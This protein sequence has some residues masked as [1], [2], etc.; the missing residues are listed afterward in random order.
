MT[1]QIQQIFA[2]PIVA[3]GAS[4]AALPNVGVDAE[5]G[6]CVAAGL[7]CDFGK[8]MQAASAT[9]IAPAIAPQTAKL[10]P[11]IG[12]QAAAAMILQSGGDDPTATAVFAP[13]D[14]L[15]LPVDARDIPFTADPAS[16]PAQLDA[17]SVPMVAT[18]FTL[19]MILP[20]QSPLPPILPQGI[21]VAI[22][23]EP[24]A[25][26]QPLPGL[27]LPPSGERAAPLA[28]NAAVLPVVAHGAP[29]ADLSVVLAPT[30]TPTAPAQTP[31]PT[32]AT[33]VDAAPIRLPL[34]A[35]P[36]FAPSSGPVANPALAAD[37]PVS[38]PADILA[39]APPAAAPNPARATPAETAF[40]LRTGG[41][42]NPAL[43]HAGAIS[44]PLPPRHP[45]QSPAVPGESPVAA[46][47]PD[48]AADTA[49]APDKTALPLIG[50][51]A[52]SAAP[53]ATPGPDPAKPTPALLAQIASPPA[54]NPPAAN[55]PATNL[56]TATP[57]DAITLPPRLTADLVTLAKTLPNGPIQILLNPAELGNLRFEIHQ[58]ADHL[59][60]V[61]AVE[62]PETMDLLRRNADQLLGEFRA[63]GFS[64][65][66]LSFGH[67][68]QQNSQQRNAPAPPDPQ[69]PPQERVFSPP[70]LPAKSPHASPEMAAASGL[71]LRL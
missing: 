45:S 67:W 29:D 8:L 39:A 20:P 68:D 19:P 48:P 57:A 23:S 43:P 66:S 55:P 31:K 10:T 32:P 34:V 70:Q 35:T 24:P 37:G 9:L 15:A 3:A 63:A 28:T 12:A 5:G 44:G 30:R 50:P 7:E 64:G 14:A 51:S 59:R 18:N 60:V 1:P 33:S 40:R 27:P 56:P 54:A 58:N 13:E 17:M 53:L 42:D 62:R 6:A 21:D 47:P 11:D 4:S 65:A 61:L 69:Q 46:V 25:P 22:R 71:N 36:A 26:I 2:V 41:A 16:V 49:A 52:E 38:R